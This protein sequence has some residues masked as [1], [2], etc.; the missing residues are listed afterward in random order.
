MKY[1]YNKLVICILFVSVLISGML[2]V[3][4]VASKKPMES[5]KL[6]TSVY[7]EKGDSLWTIAEK[8]YTEENQSIKAY[9]NEIKT[10]NHLSSNVIK[11][12]QYL[13]IPYYAG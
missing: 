3:K 12:G 1:L 8:Y 10:C 11:E 4:I 13:I 7:I 2:A 6:V 9:I 5:E